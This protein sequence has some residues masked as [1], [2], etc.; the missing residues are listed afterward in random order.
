[1]NER[2]LRSIIS[3][4]VEAMERVLNEGVD[5]NVRDSRGRT[6]LHRAVAR[7]FPEGVRLLLR[8]GANPKLR[9][10]K[11][12]TPL[13]LAERMLLESSSRLSEL[14]ERI[15]LELTENQGIVRPKVV[16]KMKRLLNLPHRLLGSIHH[17][18]W[19]RTG[20]LI[21]LATT[22][23]EIA[24][25]TREGE[26]LIYRRFAKSWGILTA[27][28]FDDG[29]RLLVGTKAPEIWD[30]SGKK[31][32][33]KLK[34]KYD[35]GAGAFLSPNNRL[36]AAY[37]P[38][39]RRFSVWDA[40][41]GDVVLRDRL[42]RG[43][44]DLRALAFSPDSQR[45]ALGDASAKVFVV[46]IH[47]N[48]VKSAV[49]TY[50]RMERLKL[51]WDERD[52]RVEMHVSVGK[53]PEVRLLWKEEGLFA[54]AHSP[55]EGALLPLLYRVDPDT[56][57]VDPVLPKALLEAYIEESLRL[58][59]PAPHNLFNHPRGLA[60]VIGNV[61]LLMDTSFNVL[62]R[63]EGSLVPSPDGEYYVPFGAH[64]SLSQSVAT[65]ESD[66]G[67]FSFRLLS[68]GGEILEG[69]D[70]PHSA[71]LG[72][73]VL[74]DR[75]LIL[76]SRDGV[77]EVGSESK[78]ILNG[79]VLAFS[80]SKRADYLLV[81]DEGGA[82][83]L[84]LANGEVED[85]RP[86]TLPEALNYS[87]LVSP[88]GKYIV[89]KADG[90]AFLY[91]TDDLNEAVPL[92]DGEHVVYSAAFVPGSLL[93][94]ESAGDPQNPPDIGRVIPP[95]NRLRRLSL[96]SLEETGVWAL[97]RYALPLTLEHDAILTV[98][99]GNFAWNR[100]SMLGEDGNWE[101][102]AINVE[103]GNPFSCVGRETDR[104]LLFA[105][106]GTDVLLLTLPDL[107]AE[108]L[109]FN[110]GMLPEDNFIDGAI[111][112]KRLLLLSHRQVWRTS[113]LV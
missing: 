34:G 18:A 106:G 25:F 9:D 62:A 26:R 16:G 75:R 11:G 13:D 37:D 104:G 58:R 86:I 21:G 87:M 48:V 82:H 91:R 12:R 110:T 54:I 90:W 79:E 98:G 35:T 73:T 92:T 56:L 83:L 102:L 45:L 64:I 29:E 3:K 28:P 17:V 107:K 43:A 94:M 85:V 97:Q 84:S 7:N 38:Q 30:I 74:S 72:M 44:G 19:N 14:L 63:M 24:L 89:L 105:M 2:L 59:R 93:L 55:V 23:D 47:R 31:R 99:S 1:M 96:P 22:H 61:T 109:R 100:V 5:L 4:D 6:Y 41:Q 39:G 103:H 76:Y 51:V 15:V 53:D 65:T 111:V 113:R 71:L 40:S 68:S 49:L 20:E 10:K 33:L 70:V 42:P 69:R 32:I 67:I 57:N 81:G 77:Y 27:T 66:S 52:T 95:D 50:A 112:G 36:V 108:V 8:W 80:H 78:A 88:D 60:V 46:D 101:A